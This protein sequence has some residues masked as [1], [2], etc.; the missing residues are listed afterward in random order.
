MLKI[1]TG[2]TR[3]SVSHLFVL[4]AFIFKTSHSSVSNYGSMRRHHD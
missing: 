4:R 2:D 1:T 3:P